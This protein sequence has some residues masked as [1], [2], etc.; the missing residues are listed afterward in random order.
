MVSEVA[1]GNPFVM[2]RFTKMWQI[3]TKIKQNS[4]IDDRMVVRFL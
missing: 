3:A 1:V 2:C 4:V